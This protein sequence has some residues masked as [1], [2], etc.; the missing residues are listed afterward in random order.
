MSKK[1]SD[2]IN[3]LMLSK[4][5]LGIFFIVLG[6]CGVSRD[7]NESILSLGD[8]KYMNMEVI[9][10]IIEIVCGAIL[11]LSIFMANVKA[12]T[13]WGTLVILVVWVVR[14]VM[15]KFLHGFDGVFDSFEN[16]IIWLL[17][18]SLELVIGAALLVVYKQYD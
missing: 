9:F 15:T 2:S 13:A 8:G 6:I 11:I 10:G 1:I 12:M 14:I 4:L 7:I 18:L 16:F 17:I 5:M 3:T